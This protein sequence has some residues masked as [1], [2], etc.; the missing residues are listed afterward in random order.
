[1]GACTFS[2]LSRDG[3][4]HLLFYPRKFRANSMQSTESKPPG[5]I[6]VPPICLIVSTI[7]VFARVYARLFLVRKFQIDDYLLVF[8]W[9]RKKSCNGPQIR[10]T[11]RTSW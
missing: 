7:F 2:Y 1:M 5:L 8:A 10:L 6:A 4:A 9:V 11:C 3:P